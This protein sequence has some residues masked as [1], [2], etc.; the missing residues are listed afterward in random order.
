M[1]HLAIALCALALSVAAPSAAWSQSTGQI[2]GRVL[3]AD[4][5]QP[6]ATADVNI[7]GTDL[8]V[9]T[10]ERGDFIFV[11]VPTGEHKLRV[12]RIGFAHTVVTVLVRASRSTQLTIE[13][14]T[15]PVEVEGVTA[16]VEKVRLI[17]PDVTVTH[18][19]I[20]GTE[21]RELPVDNV[22]QVVE[23]TVG[24]SDGRFRGGRVG[25]EVYRIDGLEVK[26]QSE[27][28]TQGAGLELAPSSIE[29]IEVV[30]GGFGVDNGAALS[31]VVSYVTRRGSPER[32]QGRASLSGDHWAPSDL[33]WGFTGLSMSLGGPLK[34]L[35]AGSTIFG[36]LL[37]QGLVDG[38]ARARGL[39][40][41]EPE[42]GDVDLAAEIDALSSSPTA[43]HLYCPYTSSRLPYQRGDKMIAFLRFDQPLHRNVDM[44]LTFLYNRRQQELYT[45]EFKYNPVYQLGQRTKGYLANLTIDWSTHRAGQAY[46]V[47]ARAAAMRLDRHL[48]A[49]DPWTFDERGRVAGFG[50]SDF[51]FLGEEFVRAPIEEQLASGQAVP[52]YVR[53]GGSTG[54]PF[55]PAAEGIFFT[56]GAPDIANWNVTDFIGGDLIGEIL[57]SA[58]HA[59]RAGAM[60]RL[61]EIESYERTLAY[62]PGS[63]PS[64]A[65]FY[66]TTVAGWAEAELLAAHD[67]TIQIG[68]RFE[69][70]RSGI[71]FSEDRVDFLSPV[72]DTDWH[73]LFLPRVGVAV[74]VPGTYG[75]T[76]FRFNYGL[77]AQAPDFRFFLDTTLGDSLRTDIRRQGN[78]NLTFERGTSWE[79]GLDQLLGER[80]SLGVTGYM[81]ELNNL[82][83]SSLTFSGFAE[84]QFTT[85]DFGSVRGVELTLRGSWPAF[86][87]RIGY[88]LSSAKGVTSSAF[89]DPGGG[90][91]ERRLEF[92]LAF[93]RRHS[94]DL[95]LLAGRA[96]G[97]TERKWG[98]TG[99]AALRSGYPLDRRVELVDDV[100][101]EIDERL[102]WTHWLNLRTTWDFGR[103]PGC[104]GCSFRAVLDAR[105]IF[106]QDNV[107]AL[108]RDTG[109]LAPSL[110]DLQAIAGEVPDDM[111][112]IPLES[113]RYSSQVDLNADGLITADEMRTGRFAAAL[114]RND[115]SLFFGPG[116]SLRLGIEIQF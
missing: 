23:L 65:R 35:G 100:V 59:I 77:V 103:P 9:L 17:E 39:T 1:R 93:D 81:K 58:G 101:P 28:A 29:E 3:E 41:L 54:T 44:F 110:E 64:Y 111:E 13:L 67:V 80:L 8:H 79:I 105:N 70:F 102:P 72:I 57:S 90:L 38:D 6:V 116:S 95:T 87:F 22:E 5:R 62:L 113:P 88:A 36:D 30:T 32:W 47:V 53:P 49:V 109:S 19:V 40:C 33:S 75:R 43:G 98:I 26:N 25:Q 85:G 73:T 20:L 89:E 82:I 21:L 107:I 83:T 61:Y 45:P 37:F 42:D 14:S 15:A 11:S 46:R 106:G 84:N 92:P 69:G 63:L 94:I 50:L 86:D 66:P 2:L 48:G 34:F 112:P 52:G 115:P 16:E 12:S 76:M 51:R 55:G 97:S 31:G 60:T 10:S 114:D 108:R 4:T 24:V 71:S 99:T 78:P 91:T 96:A 68:A 104:A 27:A 74:P 56:E 18:E 7:E